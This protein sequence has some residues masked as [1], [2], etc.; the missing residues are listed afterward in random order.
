MTDLDDALER[1]QSRAFEYAGGLS[2]HGPMAAEALGELGHAALIPGFVDVYEARL[3]PLEDG[4]WIERSKR[5]AARGSASRIG[6]WRVTFE[7]ELRERN[8]QDVLRNEA[9]EMIDGLFSAATHGLLRVAHAV[10]S[11]EREDSPVRRRELAFGL[12]YWAACYQRLPGVPGSHPEPGFGPRD[13]LDEAPLIP[14]AKRIPGFFTTAVR[15]LDKNFQFEKVIGR[16]DLDEVD[17][18]AFVGELCRTA[19]RLYLRN[20]QA[21]VAY[22]HAV[23]APSALRSLAPYLEVEAVGRAAGFSLQAAA[24]LHAISSSGSS[25][26]PS[27]EVQRLAEDPAEIRYRA[28]CSLEEHAIKFTAAC[29]REDALCPDR[30]LRLAAA[31]AALNL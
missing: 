5:S 15:S 26:E 20:P 10:R 19:A 30:A 18:N 1:F 9:R 24:A 4:K 17:L 2:N 8:W 21:R 22:V 23:T 7:R 25:G 16:V 14:A 11:L 31:D 27:V 6:D 3:P 13:V 28:A 12:A 29:L